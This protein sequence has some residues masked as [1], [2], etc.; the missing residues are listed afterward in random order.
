MRSHKLISWKHLARLH[1]TTHNSVTYAERMHTAESRN[2]CANMQIPVSLSL[3]FTSANGK[4]KQLGENEILGSGNFCDGKPWNSRE[5]FFLFASAT[6]SQ[7]YVIFS[8]IL[9]KFSFIH[10]NSNL[11]WF[12]IYFSL[13]QINAPFKISILQRR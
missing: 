6:N 12:F 7:R 3:V 9:I 2:K 11:I 8:F 13:F 1:G 10:F 5:Q 4:Q